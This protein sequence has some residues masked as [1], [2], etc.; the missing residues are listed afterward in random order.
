MRFDVRTKS[1]AKCVN[2]LQHGLA[3]AIDLEFIQDDCWLGDIVDV[4]ADVELSK[5]LNGR[6]L[7]LRNSHIESTIEIFDLVSLAGDCVLDGCDNYL[8]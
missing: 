4:C 8:F 7:S 5:I 6:S 1:E 3:M 2:C